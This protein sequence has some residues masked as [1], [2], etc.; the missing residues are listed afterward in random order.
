MFQGRM[1]LRGYWVFHL[2]CALCLNSHDVSALLPVPLSVCGKYDDA[3]LLAQQFVCE[4]SV[5]AVDAADSVTA[6][7]H[8][9]D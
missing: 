4:Y 1:L 8:A 7:E 9:V 3:V 5:L 2:G 6:F